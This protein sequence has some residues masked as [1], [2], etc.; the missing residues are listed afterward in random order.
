[1]ATIHKIEGDPRT[2][3]HQEQRFTD[4]GSSPGVHVAKNQ[5]NV[6]RADS[7]ILALHDQSTQHALHGLLHS[8]VDFEQFSLEHV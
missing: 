8:I 5:N 3:D 7:R 1:M 6:P 2:Q 4:G